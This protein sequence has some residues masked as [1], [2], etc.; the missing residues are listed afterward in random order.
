ML[1]SHVIICTAYK[2]KRYHTVK[3]NWPKLCPPPSTAEL[4]RHKN[5]L[6]TVEQL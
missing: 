6:E 2:K 1:N 3:K 4:S 5:Y